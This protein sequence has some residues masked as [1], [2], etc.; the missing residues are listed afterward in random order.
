MFLVFNGLIKKHKKS[1]KD[2][3]INQRLIPVDKWQAT[4]TKQN[5]AIFKSN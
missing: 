2:S 3:I 4:G 5:P 1:S